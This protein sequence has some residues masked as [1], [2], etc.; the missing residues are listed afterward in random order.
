MVTHWEVIMR[1]WLVLM[2]LL[3]TGCPETFP[4]PNCKNISRAAGMNWPYPC[5]MQDGWWAG[6]CRSWACVRDNE[7]CRALNRSA[8]APRDGGVLGDSAMAE[9]IT[10]STEP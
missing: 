2:G 10:A 1:V 3:V 5:C 4:P 6:S 9:T 7:E 8:Q